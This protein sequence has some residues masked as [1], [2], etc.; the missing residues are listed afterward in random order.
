MKRLATLI[1]FIIIIC[2]I[3]CFS[4]KAD[5][6]YDLGLIICEQ[7][8]ANFN[9]L[10]EDFVY[11]YS[12]NINFN[13][14]GKYTIN[15]ILKNGETKNRDVIVA[16][17]ESMQ[18]GIAY[19][20][21]KNSIDMKRYGAVNGSIIYDSTNYYSYINETY[22]GAEYAYSIGLQQRLCQGRLTLSATAV[23]PFQNRYEG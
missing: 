11:S 3:T 8:K 12:G 9:D 4:I 22:H 16:S 20:K 23:L 18:K 1:F 5:T 6:E 2:G 19:T 17:S 21:Y 10:D 14:E 13:E 15:Y 7:S